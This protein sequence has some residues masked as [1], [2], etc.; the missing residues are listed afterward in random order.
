MPI[1]EYR[2]NTCGKTFES[3]QKFSD[4]P[5]TNC[6]EPPTLDCEKKGEGEVTRLLSSPSFQF[7]GSGF[8]ITDY[9]KKGSSPS[10]SS[11]GG[12]SKP[13]APAAPSTSTKKD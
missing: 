12:D 3:M 1:Y 2:C 11:T 9:A 8:Y 13:A 4:T 10:S 5:Y 6:G 7:K